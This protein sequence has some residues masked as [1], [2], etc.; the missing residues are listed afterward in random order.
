MKLPG[1]GPGLPGKEISFLLCL[2]TPPKGRG[3]R[4]TCRPNHGVLDF[5]THLAFACPPV[6][7]D[8][9][10]CPLPFFNLSDLPTRKSIL[11]RID[12]EMDDGKGF[13][14][15]FQIV[16]VDGLKQSFVI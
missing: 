5:D 4:G 6:G 13:K 11:L 2:F 12:G 16:D 7:R 9:D 1:Q 10:I 14:P 15:L 8:F 3:L